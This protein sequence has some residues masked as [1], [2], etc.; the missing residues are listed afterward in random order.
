MWNVSKD[1][2]DQGDNEEIIAYSA[3]QLK[4]PQ[5]FLERVKDLRVN[6]EIE[7]F[8]LL[9]LND[10]R[11]FE[12][13]IRPQ[14]VENKC[15]GCVLSFSDVSERKKAEAELN[16]IHHELVQASR[17]AGMA[18]VAT[19]VLHNVG[20]VLNSVNT[21]ASVVMD[22]VRGSK[23]KGVLRMATLLE[24]NR[25]NLIG[26]LSQDNR[27]EQ[28]L[29]YLKTLAEHLGEEHTTILH[30]LGDLTKNIEHIKEI[31]AMQQSYAKVSGVEEI[32]SAPAL[33]NDA[34]RMHSTALGRHQIKVVKNFENVPDILV[35]KHKVLQILVNLIGN[36]KYSLNES[37][38]EDRQLTL[39]ISAKDGER[40]HLGVT[41]NGVGIASENLVRIF[42]HGFTTKRNG[43]GF[44]LHSGFLAAKE[45]GGTLHVHSDGVNKGAT[46]TLELPIKC[47]SKNGAT[48]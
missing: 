29:I 20:N 40:L 10:G 46:F 41:D 45:M 36:A 31:V 34:L 26:F 1:L 44:G 9:E 18:E 2:L 39:S 14:W 38:R 15:V 21:S 4:D 16:S 35:D 43:H 27:A 7:A 6:A 32:H 25:N 8:D 30:E 23:I 33:I 17:Q 42:S 3:T 24:E 12:R 37:N 13:T 11:A 48:K 28:V 19:N 47:S 5:R 22:Q